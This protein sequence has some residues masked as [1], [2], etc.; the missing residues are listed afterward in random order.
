M[1]KK[2]E[3]GWKGRAGRERGEREGRRRKRVAPACKV[4]GLRWREEEGGET[5][6][7]KASVLLR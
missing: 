6:E 2:K 1:I 7:R 4:E 3:Q 5:K